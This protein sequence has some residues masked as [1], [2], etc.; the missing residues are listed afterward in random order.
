MPDAVGPYFVAR[1]RHGG[2]ALLENLKKLRA[3][4]RNRCVL[5]TMEFMDAAALCGLLKWRAG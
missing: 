2:P 1:G 3:R 5:L 4:A